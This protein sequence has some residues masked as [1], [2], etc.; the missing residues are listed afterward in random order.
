MSSER[1]HINEIFYS[2]QGE[3]THAGRPCVFVRLTGCNL[4]C[5]WC[6]TEYAF[7]EGRQMTIAEVAET[8]R[9]YRCELVEVTGGEP[10]LQEGVY[11]LTEA[12]LESGKTV[13]IETSGAVD[14]GRLDPRVI[15]IMDL[16]CPGS[17][18]CERNL[19]SNL[20]HLTGRDEI[21]FVV[22]D[23]ADYEWARD[24]IAARDLARRVGALLLSPVLGKLAPAALAAWILED[25]LPARMQLQMHKQIWPGI[26][27][28]V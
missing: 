14:A 16:K 8:V 13:M 18:E 3:S 12:M 23:R 28:G 11:P 21:K 2:I 22:A 19:W 5:K 24:A 17:G 4:R 25:R 15:K 20:E 7:Y 6:D 1:L 10:L 26:L 27:R 9:G